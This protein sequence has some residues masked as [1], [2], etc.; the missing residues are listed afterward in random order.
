MVDADRVIDAM[1]V[2]DPAALKAPD[3]TIEILRKG[4]GISSCVG[5]ELGL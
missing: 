1:D 5:A 3:F 4:D 2:V